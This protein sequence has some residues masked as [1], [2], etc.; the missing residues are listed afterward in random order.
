MCT[1]LYGVSLNLGH[2]PHM[3][4]TEHIIVY[5]IILSISAYF[6]RT[7]GQENVHLKTQIL[8]DAKLLFFCQISEADILNGVRGIH[9][10]DNPVH[11]SPPL[12][13]QSR[14]HGGFTLI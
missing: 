6:A 4:Q 7:D 8:S 11:R 3:V 9:R 12:L 5:M 14:S 10:F 2:V 13:T 1:W